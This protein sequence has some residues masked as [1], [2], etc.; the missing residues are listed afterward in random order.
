MFG[1]VARWF[2][3][4]SPGR[5]QDDEVLSTTTHDVQSTPQCKANGI[6]HQNNS[7]SVSRRQLVRDSIVQ[8]DSIE[9]SVEH[10]R[11]QHETSQPC[12]TPIPQKISS[13]L[14]SPVSFGILDLLENGS[15][16]SDRLS[17]PIITSTSP[18]LGEKSAASFQCEKQQPST[19]SPLE[20]W[21]EKTI[22]DDYSKT[23]DS[24]GY[25]LSNL[26]KSGPVPLGEAN[27]NNNLHG[28]AS[29]NSL[30]NVQIYNSP[31]TNH[32][33]PV[34]E[35]DIASIRSLTAESQM[36]SMKNEAT[37][38]KYSFDATPK[39]CQQ[40]SIGQEN[41]TPIN[42]RDLLRSQSLTTPGLYAFKTP[43]EASTEDH[44]ENIL[45]AATSTYATPTTSVS[46]DYAS[47]Q[48]SLVCDT[49]LGFRPTKQLNL[50][51]AS[52]DISTPQ[53]FFHR[54]PFFL[55]DES[56]ASSSSGTP[57]LMSTPTCKLPS[58]CESQSP[59][60]PYQSPCY[61]G[62]PLQ[63]STNSFEHQHLDPSI[64]TPAP[65]NIT[66]NNKVGFGVTPHDPR[67]RR[68]HDPDAPILV[69]DKSFS[70]RVE[71]AMR[72]DAVR[73]KFR[74]SN[75]QQQPVSNLHFDEVGEEN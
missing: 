66:K 20:D 23:Q 22:D 1:F 4:C 29:T 16:L 50:P 31:F 68:L 38:D 49:P 75:H 15:G 13:R 45:S 48:S 36:E 32:R 64:H 47:E 9:F 42:E 53:R 5:E 40:T 60:L 70:K 18:I 34:G 54:G 71:S 10:N 57:C 55:I 6:R 52:C 19:P 62:K 41:L 35:Q 63:D 7:S 67:Y 69:Q 56:P 2:G 37:D 25:P 72:R 73:A 44:K 59:A 43:Q 21:K 3:F 11:A 46:Q 51:S 65:A 26:I 33:V 17:G 39:K 61:V 28:G 12:D 58:D 24:E 14:A 27:I 74:K 8:L 30:V